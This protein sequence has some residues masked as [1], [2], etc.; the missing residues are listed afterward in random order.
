MCVL[1]LLRVRVKIYKSRHRPPL[2]LLSV[3]P[4]QC[5]VILYFAL[6]IPIASYFPL[7]FF[8]FSQMSAGDDMVP[9]ATAA[10]LDRLEKRL[11]DYV[12]DGGG[13]GIYFDYAR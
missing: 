11:L 8:F 1:C 3:L 7:F 10:S 13:G 12:S 2:L 5:Y 6:Q 9:R 4:I